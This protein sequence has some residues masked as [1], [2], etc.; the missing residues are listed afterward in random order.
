MRGGAP[1]LQFA[2]PYDFDSCRIVNAP[3]TLFMQKDC[4]DEL[5]DV[6]EEYSM[7]YILCP[8]RGGMTRLT[9]VYAIQL[10]SF[11]CN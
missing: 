4:I 1:Q 3:T 11:Q 8:M 7:E 5:L 9:E 6:S 10:K 2:V